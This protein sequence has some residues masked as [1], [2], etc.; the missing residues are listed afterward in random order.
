MQGGDALCRTQNVSAVWCIELIF[1]S[2]QQL[3]IL[4]C[5]AFVCSALQY[6]NLI[7]NALHCTVLQYIAARCNA[8]QRSNV[9][10]RKLVADGSVTVMVNY[11]LNLTDGTSAVQSMSVQLREGF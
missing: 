5:S 10:V 3:S 4:Q 6:R 11:G 1:C 8:A 7:H 2:I 9:P